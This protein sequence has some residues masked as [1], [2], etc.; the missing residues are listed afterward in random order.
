M[1]KERRKVSKSGVTPHAKSFWDRKFFFQISSASSSSF[2]LTH[3]LNVSKTRHGAFSPFFSVL[4]G[5]YKSFFFFSPRRIFRLCCINFRAFRRI[6][7]TGFLFLRGQ[8]V[9]FGDAVGVSKQMQV[10]KSVQLVWKSFGEKYVDPIKV[11]SH[12][13]R[14]RLQ[15]ECHQL[16]E[17]KHF[18]ALWKNAR[19]SA[20][21]CNFFCQTYATYL[22]GGGGIFHAIKICNDSIL[23]DF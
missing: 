19:P 16:S 3:L 13:R 7:I 18:I 8:C 21:G 11:H 14:S 4:S 6:C 23:A 20:T 12:D 15:R 9:K 10:V 5:C 22:Q 17:T 1:P 2:C